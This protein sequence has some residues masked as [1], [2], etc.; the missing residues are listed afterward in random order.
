MTVLFGLVLLGSLALLSG[1]MVRWLGTRDERRDAM[2]FAP[3]VIGL[4]WM[5]GFVAGTY[6]LL[7]GLS[8]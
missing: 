7:A 5:V 4:A 2:R 1:P 6:L 3:D 8:G